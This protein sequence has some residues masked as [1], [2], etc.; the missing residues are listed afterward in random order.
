MENSYL[1]HVEIMRLTVK[2]GDVLVFKVDRPLSQQHFDDLK[3]SLKVALNA[4]FAG[5]PPQMLLLDKDVEVFVLAR[6]I[7]DQLSNPV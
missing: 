3:K 2:P 1:Q 5:D 4:V 6:A 7:V